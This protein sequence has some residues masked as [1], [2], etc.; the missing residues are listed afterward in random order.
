M[1]ILLVT[2]RNAEKSV[3]E[4]VEDLGVPARIHV[5]DADVAALLSVERIAR[6]LSR[7]DLKGVSEIIIPGTVAGDAS[8][9][10]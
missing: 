9:I 10:T 2:A 5:C 8:L 6:E 7:I 4:C 1:P 3:R